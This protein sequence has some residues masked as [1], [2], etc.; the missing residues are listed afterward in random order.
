MF[1]FLILF[2]LYLFVCLLMPPAE[3]YRI[4]GYDVGKEGGDHSCYVYGRKKDGILHIEKIVRGDNFQEDTATEDF[5][6]CFINSEYTKRVG[7]LGD[8]A[9]QGPAPVW[10]K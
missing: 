3:T 4:L 10:R 2:A 8:L 9:E 1:V 6:P 7:V 5:R